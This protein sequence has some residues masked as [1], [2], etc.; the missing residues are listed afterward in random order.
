MKTMFAGD[1][2]YNRVM[3]KVF[4][5]VLVSVLTLLCCLPVVTAGAAL[6]AAC[7]MYMKMAKNQ[8]GTIVPSYFAAFKSNLKESVAGWLLLLAGMAVLVASLCLYRQ[9]GIG[10]GMMIVPTGLYCVY[11]I[12]YFCLR[13]RFAETTA[14][15]L[16]NSLKFFLAFLPLSLFLELYLAAL[17]ALFLWQPMLFVVQ[18]FM[19]VAG[20][21]YLPCV[22]IGK[23]MDRYIEEKELAR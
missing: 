19:T 20:V 7:A 11:L 2:P 6:T 3:T 14:S 17:L 23:K 15:A 1:T 12:W 18:I 4:D 22:L 21:F 13:A 16:K 10:Y 9:S 5:V 8:E